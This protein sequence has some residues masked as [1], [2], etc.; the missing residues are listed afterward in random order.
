MCLNGIISIKIQKIYNF[1]KF[2]FLQYVRFLSIL[3][4]IINYLLIFKT[5]FLNDTR[6]S[7][8]TGK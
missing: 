1:Y 7:K 6:R 2:F 4:K 8:K 3:K 5:F